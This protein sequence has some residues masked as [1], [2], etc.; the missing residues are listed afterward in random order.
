MDHHLERLVCIDRGVIV[1]DGFLNLLWFHGKLVL[2]YI[3]H[4]LRSYYQVWRSISKHLT[5]HCL[6]F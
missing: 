3:D 4:I 6:P 2:W 5:S 1:G